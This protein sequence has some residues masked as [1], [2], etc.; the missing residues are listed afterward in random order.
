MTN[1]R[2]HEINASPETEVDDFDHHVF[3]VRVRVRV[4][5]RIK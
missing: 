3:R 5:V 2:N 1:N 4:R